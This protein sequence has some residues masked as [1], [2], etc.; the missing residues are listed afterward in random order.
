MNAPS[1]VVTFLFTDIEGSTRRWEADTDTMRIS[2]ETHNRLLRDTVEAHGGQVFSYTGDGMCAVFA[3]PRSAVDA[4]IA[5]QLALELPVRMGIATGEAELRGDDY[6]GTVLNRTA[7]VMSAGHGEQILLDGATAGLISGVDLLE[8]GPRRLRDISKPVVIFQVQATGLRADFPPLKT[9]DSTPGNLRPPATSFIGREAELAEL[10]T[11]L[12]AHRL[13]TLTGVGGVGK[14]RLALELASHSASEFPD[15][16]WVVELAAVGDPAAVPEAA[17]AV[18]G[19]RQQ[20]ELTL[21]ASVG[22]ALEGRSRLL[23]FDNCEHVL[24][25]AADMIE[26]ILAASSTVKILATSREG[27]GIADEQLWPVPSLDLDSSATALFVERA[28]AVAPAISLDD[29]GET[30]GEICGRLD[31]IPL[32]IELAASRMLSMTTPRC[33]NDSTTG[34]GCWSA[35]GAV[36]SDIKRY[37][38]PCNGPTTYSRPDEKGLLNRCSV[39]RGGFDLAGACALGGSDDD[40]ATLDLLDAL[41][42]KSFWSPVGHLTA[43]GS[44]CW[45]R[46]VGSPKNN[47][48]LRRES[49]AAR[50]AHAQYFAGREADL[51]ALWDGPRQRE[52]YDLVRSRIGEPALRVPLG[53]RQQYLDS[54]ATIAIYAAFI[55]VSVEQHEP[56]GWAEELIIPAK[57]VDHPRLAQLYVFA[58][59]CYWAGRIDDAAAY[60]GPAL[61]ALESG[62]YREVP[63]DRECALGGF[64]AGVGQPEK[65]VELCSKVIARGHGGHIFARSALVSALAISGRLDEARELSAILAS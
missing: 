39:F 31:G 49:D 55:G 57:A 24:D 16:V 7:R 48:W 29:E 50:T 40:L 23:V 11:V 33:A 51:F 38:T 4:A 42:R 56:I 13:L 61:S 53:H 21:S 27:L 35:H 19:I 5:A 18:L 43:R 59:L 25:G 37:A 17:A 6:F 1:G 2:L 58:S 10:Q 12:K 64:Y 14:T 8:V 44:R 65:W 15:G 47:S 3:S 20:P 60:V 41:V 36:R 34:S 30:I 22:S 63:F 26:G 28:S 45:R 9:I 32:A 54:A 52:A 62:R 46:F